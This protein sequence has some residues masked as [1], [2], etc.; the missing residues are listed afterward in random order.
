[1]AVTG[2]CGLITAIKSGQAEFVGSFFICA[3]LV[4]AGRALSDKKKKGTIVSVL[5]ACVLIGLTYDPYLDRK[6]TRLNSSH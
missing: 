1:M 6:S 4:L 3:I 5:L 2:V